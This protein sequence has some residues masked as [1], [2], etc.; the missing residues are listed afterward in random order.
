MKLLQILI[1]IVPIA[2]FSQQKEE[3]FFSFDKP[4]GN[5]AVTCADNQ[6]IQFFFT[7]H[8]EGKP[9]GARVFE[10]VDG[11]AIPFPDSSFQENFT[12][13]L[14]IFLDRQNRL[15]I[16]DHGNYAF[17]TP[18]LFGFDAQSG[19]LLYKYD[20]PKDVVRKWVMLNDLTVTP[21]GEYIFI[22]APGIF[23]KRSSIIIFN[24]RE[25]TSRRILTDH[26]S[27]MRKKVLIEVSGKKMRYLFGL[28]KI[29]PGV[30]GI[31]VDR[32]G[33]YLYYTALADTSVYRLPIAACIDHLVSDVKL[34]EIS[35]WVGNRPYCDGIRMD[36]KENLYLTD[37]TNHRITVMDP[38]GNNHTLIE[39]K[40]IRWADGLSIGAD[41]YLYITDSALQHVIMKSKKNI[42][43][44]QPFG[45]WRIKLIP[46]HIR[47]INL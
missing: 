16:L 15:W 33:K 12:S 21:N 24:T 11:K 30:D 45:I 35:D 42:S 47:I 10:I 40:R 8:P 17:K 2:L 44:Y 18:R 27:V 29:R 36:H 1:L 34:E 46:E 31:D 26:H 22:S 28:L 43:K 38:A 7:L 13:P 9:K 19:T 39:N 3:L 37:F 25:R 6:P 41:G 5:I 23:K 4:L 20:F 14:G 32:R